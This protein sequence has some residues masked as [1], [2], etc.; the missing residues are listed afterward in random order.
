MAEEDQELDRELLE[1][2]QE[3]ASEDLDDAE[4]LE[5]GDDLDL[6]DIED[7]NE[8]DLQGDET[9]S[10]LEEYYRE[11]GIENEPDDQAAPT[12]TKPKKKPAPA[13]APSGKEEARKKVMDELI[14]KTRTG[15]TY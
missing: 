14:E 2:Q 3:N 9:D 11:L 8:E 4:F 15:P 6:P 7:D 5:H 10:D 12:K 1:D 13:A